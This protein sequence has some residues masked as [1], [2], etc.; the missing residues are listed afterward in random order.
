MHLQ[1]SVI[2]GDDEEFAVDDLRSNVSP[3]NKSSIFNR[4]KVDQFEMRRLKIV[5]VPMDNNNTENMTI[6][7]PTVLNNQSNISQMPFKR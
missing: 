4:S 2:G 3:Q 7:S 1:A 6:G 5:P